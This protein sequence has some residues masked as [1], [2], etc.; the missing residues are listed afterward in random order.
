MIIGIFL[1]L[2]VSGFVYKK[3]KKCFCIN[4]IMIDIIHSLLVLLFLKCLL[5]LWRQMTSRSITLNKL[6]YACFIFLRSNAFFVLD[7][8]P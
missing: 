5:F 6:P 2:V 1:L 8:N 3:L 4:L 7:Q